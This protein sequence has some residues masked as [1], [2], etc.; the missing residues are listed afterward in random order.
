MATATLRWSL[1]LHP[2]QTAPILL[3]EDEERLRLPSTAAL[4]EI[5][6]RVIAADGGRAALP[7]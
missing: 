3:V 4:R 7:C 2:T 1:R 6:Y 5:G